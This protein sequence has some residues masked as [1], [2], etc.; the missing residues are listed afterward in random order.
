MKEINALAP[1]TRD[2]KIRRRRRQRERQKSLRLAKQQLCTH[3]THVCTFLCRH[4]TTTTRKCLISRFMEE[5]NKLLRNFLSHYELGYV[6]LGIQLPSWFK[7]TSQVL[8]KL[9][10]FLFSFQ[11]IFSVYSLFLYRTQAN[12]W[13]RQIVSL[14]SVRLSC[15]ECCQSCFAVILI[16]KPYIWQ[17]KWVG[18]VAMKKKLD[19]REFIFQAMSSLPSPSLDLK[20][21]N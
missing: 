1:G 20:V 15:W 10:I 17:S 2:L 8:V 3:I 4:C 19:E 18:T 9:L 16:L 5:V 6:F 13:R 21:P 11:G 14:F 7:I 12:G